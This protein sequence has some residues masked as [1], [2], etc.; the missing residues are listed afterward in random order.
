MCILLLSTFCVSS[1]N[2]SLVCS[3]LI[4]KI[5][6]LFGIFSAISVLLTTENSDYLE[7]W[8]LPIH[9]TCAS[10]GINGCLIM[11]FH[12]KKAFGELNKCHL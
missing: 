6:A 3:F 9:K 2:C 8:V 11:F 5:C 7:I 10:F 12:Q 1:I 4:H